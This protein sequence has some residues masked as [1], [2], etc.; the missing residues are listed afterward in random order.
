MPVLKRG[1][2][3]MGCAVQE[4]WPRN[5]DLLHCTCKGQFKSWE[6][7]LPGRGWRCLAGKA[8]MWDLK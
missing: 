5:V 1:A 4:S 3:S 6:E 2:L 8:P 7:E